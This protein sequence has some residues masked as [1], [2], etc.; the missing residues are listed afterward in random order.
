MVRTCLVRNLCSFLMV[1]EEKNLVG[2]I[3]E[4]ISMV[5]LNMA[6]PK[7]FLY[8]LIHMQNVRNSK[9]Q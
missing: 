9:T 7:F 8:I 1:C 6:L 3:F 5:I 2:I 4:T